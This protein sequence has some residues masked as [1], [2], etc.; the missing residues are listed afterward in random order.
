MFKVS[1]KETPES[2]HHHLVPLVLTLKIFHT[3]CFNVSTGNFEQVIAGRDLAVR[4][5]HFVFQLFQCTRT[6]KTET[7]FVVNIL[8]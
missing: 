6:K 4:N 3:P 8:K 5:R 7:F 1:N 2:R